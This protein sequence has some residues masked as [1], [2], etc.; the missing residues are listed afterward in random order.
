LIKRLGHFDRSLDGR[1]NPQSPEYPVQH[2][3]VIERHAACSAAA[4][5]SLT[6]FNLDDLKVESSSRRFGKLFYDFMT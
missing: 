4:A 6:H 3:P 1:A 5:K 2:A